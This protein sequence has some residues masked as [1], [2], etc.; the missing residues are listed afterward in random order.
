[1][2]LNTKLLVSTSL[3]GLTFMFSGCMKDG[4]DAATAFILTTDE[5]SGENCTSGGI[6]LDTGFDDDNSGLLEADEI[7]STRYVCNGDDGFSTLVSTTTDT[8][9]MCSN[10][11]IKV[12]IGLDDDRS[13]TLDTEEID[14]SV[15]L[16]NGTDG[17]DGL[18]SLIETTSEPAGT[19]CELG[20]LKV[21]TGLDTNRSGTLDPSE[22]STTGYICNGMNGLTTLVNSTPEPAG[23]NCEN[24]GI[25]IDTGLDDDGSGILEAAE[26]DDTVYVCNGADADISALCLLN[27]VYQTITLPESN[28]TWLDRNLGADSPAGA[29]DY[30]QWGRGSDGHEDLNSTVVNGTIATITPNDSNFYSNLPDWSSDDPDGITRE[31]LWSTPY[32]STLNTNQV[33]PCGYIVPTQNDLLNLSPTDRGILALPNAGYRL[34]TGTVFTNM[35]WTGYWTSEDATSAEYNEPGWA[36]IVVT[37]TTNSDFGSGYS[38]YSMGHQIRCIKP[39]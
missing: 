9:E 8:G 17:S 37:N 29:G 36:K 35:G 20:G 27:T 19:N 24:G 32:D 4:K 14:K 31:V 25:K 33:C 22:I 18:N 34:Y 21:E 26:I 7:D 1:M 2:K 23:A 6:R 3:V 10:G 11:G 13:G 5:A 30:Y 28:T 12:D 38:T 15:Y 16:C 39:Q